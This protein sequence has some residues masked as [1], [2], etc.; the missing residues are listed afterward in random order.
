[1]LS[2]VGCAGA[3]YALRPLVDGFASEPAGV[4]LALLTAAA[5]LFFCRPPESQKLLGTC[6]AAGLNDSDQD[7]HDRALLYYRCVHLCCPCELLVG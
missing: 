4:K 6:L 2:I 7:V 3:P 5:K 1:V